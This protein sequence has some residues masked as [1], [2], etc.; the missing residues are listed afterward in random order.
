MIVGKDYLKYAFAVLSFCVKFSHDIIPNRMRRMEDSQSGRLRKGSLMG[1]LNGVSGR[2]VL[3][4]QHYS[5][6]EKV[7]PGKCVHKDS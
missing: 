7:H 2:Q 3:H 5:S 6:L 4:V 1:N